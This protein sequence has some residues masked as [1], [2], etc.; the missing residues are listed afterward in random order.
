MIQYYKKG[1]INI[2]N[3]NQIEKVEKFYN[4]KKD[5]ILLKKDNGCK[6]CISHTKDTLGYTRITYNGKQERLFRVLY[7]LEFGEMPKGMV[8]RHKCDNPSCC[9]LEH[10][11]IGTVRDNVMDMIKRGR[12]PDR[13]AHPNVI[14][15]KNKFSKLSEEDV[16]E[17]YFSNLSYRKLSKKY[18]VSI[19][20]I[21]DIKHKIIWKWFTDKLD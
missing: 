1:V 10:L 19:T 17:I 2:F 9:N 18:S 12:C 16:K 14:G 4:S 11:E 7:Q 20:T 13:K 5:I 15:T 6:E 8:L 21:S 3:H